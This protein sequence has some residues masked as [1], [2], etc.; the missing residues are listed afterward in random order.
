MTGTPACVAGPAEGWRP[1]SVRF[2]IHA[3][4]VPAAPTCERPNADASVSYAGSSRS[5]AHPAAVDFR[6][7]ARWLLW[8]TL[9]CASIVVALR[10]D[11]DV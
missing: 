4:T 11:G 5:S 7:G 8:S 10:R 3:E 6:E 9:A 2:I 1:L